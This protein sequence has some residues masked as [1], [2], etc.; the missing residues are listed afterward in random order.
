MMQMPKGKTPNRSEQSEHAAEFTSN[1]QQPQE[2]TQHQPNLGFPLTIKKW[3]R[4]KDTPNWLLVVLTAVIAASEVFGVTFSGSQT[5]TYVKTTQTDLRA[6]VTFR[7]IEPLEFA[8][9]RPFAYKVIFVNTGK[10]PAY[11]TSH[12]SSHK[13]GTGVYPH[14]VEGYDRDINP[15]TLFLVQA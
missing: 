9:N 13:A 4:Q 12:K 11:K 5:C 10:T 7:R 14:E 6:Y 2:T 1:S 15:P 3:L 8:P